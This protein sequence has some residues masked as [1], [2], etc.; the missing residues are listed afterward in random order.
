MFETKKCEE[1]AC[2]TTT[3]VTTTTAAAKSSTVSLR[4]NYMT[5]FTVLAAASIFLLP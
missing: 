4:V 1:K 5:S 2:P 3:T